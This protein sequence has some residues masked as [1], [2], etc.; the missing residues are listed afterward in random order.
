[1]G[2][3]FFLGRATEVRK[4]SHA[5]TSRIVSVLFAKS[6]LAQRRSSSK[7][8]IFWNA[9]NPFRLTRSNKAEFF[10]ASSRKAWMPPRIPP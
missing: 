5:L 1:M 9:M 6:F 7:L 3:H 8:F 10:A 2:S 4:K